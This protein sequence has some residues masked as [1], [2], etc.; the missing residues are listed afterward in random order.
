M[1]RIAISLPQELLNEFDE[2]A[3][4]NGHKSRSKGIYEAMNEYIERHK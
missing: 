1:T 2:C 3:K 4:K